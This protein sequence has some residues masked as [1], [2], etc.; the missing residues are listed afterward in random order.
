MG[1]EDEE[2]KRERGGGGGGEDD[3]AMEDTMFSHRSQVGVEG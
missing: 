2:L 3:M 1:I